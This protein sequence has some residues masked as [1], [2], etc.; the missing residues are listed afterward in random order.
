MLLN[1]MGFSQKN[2]SDIRRRIKH[3]KLHKNKHR[4]KDIFNEHYLLNKVQ[5]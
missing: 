3:Y 5:K 2:P 4:A 1:N